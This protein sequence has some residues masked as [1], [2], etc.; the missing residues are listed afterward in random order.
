MQDGTNS[1]GVDNGPRRQD[2]DGY[3]YFG[4]EDGSKNDEE[5]EGSGDGG[6]GA[7]GGFIEDART[8]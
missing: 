7:T 2:F 5:E 8:G 1:L 4:V 6:A 3:T